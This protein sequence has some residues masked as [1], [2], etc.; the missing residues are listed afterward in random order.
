VGAVAATGA[1]LLVLGYL[2]LGPFPLGGLTVDLPFQGALRDPE[3]GS[4][5]KS[6]LMRG[7]V[8]LI[9][10]FFFVPGFVYGWIV[11]TM[12]SDRDVIQ[13]M[14][15]TMATMGLYLVLVFFAAQF[16]KLFEWT[17]LGSMLAV[18][19]ARGLAA[20]G[21]DNAWVFLP[22]IFL[23]CGVNLLMGSA[24]AKWA[25]MAPIFVP[26]LM[27]TESRFSPELTQ[28]AFRIGDSSTN[29]ITPMMSQFGLIYSFACRYQRRMGIGTLI[30]TMLP[31]SIIFAVAWTAFFY[32][33]VFG[34]GW[35]IGPDA[36]L[37]YVPAAPPAAS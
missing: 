12:R 27:M 30:S 14:S 1:L 35:P 22:F 29:I 6:P 7:V 10:V 23:C 21:L 5:L 15:K 18:S 32:V 9:F 13:A 2:C 3:T 17:N 34:L 28:T 4:L 11:G 25:I 33:W 24:S 16:A 31:Y 8:A 37:Y 26:M 20:L 19:G 36:P